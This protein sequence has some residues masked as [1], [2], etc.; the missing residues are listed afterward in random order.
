MVAEREY[1][2]LK[3][4]ELKELLGE[5]GL[6]TSGKKADL[7]V[8][9]QD[10]DAEATKE[11]ELAEPEVGGETQAKEVRVEPKS[12]PEGVP[13]PRNPEKWLSKFLSWTDEFGPNQ[14]RSLSEARKKAEEEATFRIHDLMEAVP[15]G[16]ARNLALWALLESPAREIL[17]KL[18]GRWARLV[19]DAINNGV[20][21]P[22]RIQGRVDAARE[23][24]KHRP[25]TAAIYYIMATGELAAIVRGK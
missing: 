11:L 23:A 4:A 1:G 21:I 13:A 20:R 3:V 7:V 12:D 14:A 16:D 10:A 15:A 18:E 17:P 2:S 22:G 6:P 9:L 25:A 24:A 5:R 8:R 19:A